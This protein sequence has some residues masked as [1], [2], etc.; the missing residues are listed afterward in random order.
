MAAPSIPQSAV[1]AIKE[2][3]NAWNGDAVDCDAA[4]AGI[5]PQAPGVLLQPGREYQEDPALHG[6]SGRLKH[7]LANIMPDFSFECGARWCG[8]MNLLL[9]M[10]FGAEATENVTEGTT[11]VGTEHN[12]TMVDK[13]TKHATL[14]ANWDT[15]L[16]EMDHFVVNEATLNWSA[17]QRAVWTFNC[18]GRKWSNSSAINTSVSSVTVTTPRDY[19]LGDYLTLQASTQSGA[20]ATFSITDVSITLSQ[21]L[22]GGVVTSGS[23]P[24]REQPYAG[25]PGWTGTFDF[26]IPR[27]S[28]TT[29]ADAHEAGTLMKAKIDFTSTATKLTGAA[30]T[31]LGAQLYLPQ[32]QITTYEQVDVG[33]I[34]ER[35]SAELTYATS[36]PSEMDS[37]QGPKLTLINNDAAYLA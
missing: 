8:R 17:G 26:T 20:L 22:D 4:S 18:L 31:Y 7:D 33:T 36:A 24:Y 23:V 11:T 14:V 35:V 5:E 29:F 13:P 21:N 34:G 28:V 27:W 3:T 9:A 2:N 1:F 19:W 16:L 30:S 37:A 32:W 12:F 15:D 6:A 10:F 25:A